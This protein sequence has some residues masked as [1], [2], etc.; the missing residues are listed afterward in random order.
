M[1]TATTVTTTQT[2][3]AHIFWGEGNGTNYK[4]RWERR[5]AEFFENGFFDRRHRS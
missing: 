4:K 5:Y 1:K 3:P 2:E